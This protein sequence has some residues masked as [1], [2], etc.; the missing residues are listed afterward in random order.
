M[1]FSSK[2]TICVIDMLS[3]DVDIY[4]FEAIPIAVIV[5]LL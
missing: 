3:K 5:G 2:L 1:P 4:R